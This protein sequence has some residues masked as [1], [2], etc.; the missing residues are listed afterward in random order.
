MAIKYFLKQKFRNCF[1]LV[2]SNVLPSYQTSISREN[3]DQNIEKIWP[4]VI[5]LGSCSRKSNIF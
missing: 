5:F 3:G 2:S 4:F 1:W